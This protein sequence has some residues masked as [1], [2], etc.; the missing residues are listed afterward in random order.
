MAAF[1]DSGTLAA[2]TR[3]AAGGRVDFQR[4]MVMR[5]ASDFDQPHPG[6]SASKSLEAS[7]NNSSGGSALPRIKTSIAPE[8]SLTRIFSDTCWVAWE[9]QVCHLSPDARNIKPVAENTVPAVQG[10]DGTG[11]ATN[12]A[13]PL[14]PKAKFAVRCG[15]S[16]SR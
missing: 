16:F 14:P 5:A 4:V 10:S 12:P 13:E 3:L 6:E 15:V 1:E 8:R 9:Q 7:L 2:L 11:H